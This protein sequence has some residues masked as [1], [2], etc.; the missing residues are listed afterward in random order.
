MRLSQVQREWLTR[1]CCYHYL[2]L[3]TSLRLSVHCAICLSACRNRSGQDQHRTA[4]GLADQPRFLAADKIE[5]LSDA[6]HSCHA[7]VCVTML[8]LL[9]YHHGLRVSEA[10]GIRLDQLNFKRARVWVRRGKNSL[11]TEQPIPGDEL[12][13]STAR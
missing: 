3:W 6:A 8:L 9:M 13:V 7:W 2:A 4:L 11:S 1:K 5:R 12:R 10:V